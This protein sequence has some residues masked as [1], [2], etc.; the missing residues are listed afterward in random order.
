MYSLIRFRGYPVVNLILQEL[1]RTHPEDVSNITEALPLLLGDSL[2][3][4]ERIEVLN[5]I[6]ILGL[7]Y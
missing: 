7:I 5:I 6:N 1:V 4:Y 2:T 3:N